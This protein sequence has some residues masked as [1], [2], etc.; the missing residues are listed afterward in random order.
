MHVPF[1]YFFISVLLKEVSLCE[2]MFL[3]S[4]SIA[5]TCK[6]WQQMASSTMS[7]STEHDS[8]TH[9]VNLF[10]QKGKE[11][12]SSLKCNGLISKIPELSD[13]CEIVFADLSLSCIM[14]PRS[15]SVR[16][17]L[18]RLYTPYIFLTFQLYLPVPTGTGTYCTLKDLFLT[19]HSV[20]IHPFIHRRMIRLHWPC[21]LIQ[22]PFLNKLLTKLLQW[23]MSQAHFWL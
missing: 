17:T 15:N 12:S 21:K 19:L 14:E 22:M 6:T 11:I 16:Y 4:T 13:S 2:R 23:K 1:H 3:C 8:P 5:E 18:K 10:C 9:I 7:D 20:W